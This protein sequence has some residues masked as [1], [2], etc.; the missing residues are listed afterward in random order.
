MSTCNCSCDNVNP[1]Q[2]RCGGVTS[3]N[4]LEKIESYLKSRWKILYKNKK[5]E[6]CPNCGCDIKQE[7]QFL[8][9]E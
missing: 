9:E 3:K 4:T 5:P 7:K 2:Y 6:K 8:T 1:E